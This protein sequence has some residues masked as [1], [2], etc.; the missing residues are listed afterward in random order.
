MH[1][2]SES[3]PAISHAAS[4]Q[5]LEQDMSGASPNG[6]FYSYTEMGLMA[7]LNENLLQIVMM[8]MVHLVT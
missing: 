8:Q 4:Y 5:V 1:Q 7:K 3:T 6:Y 2:Y